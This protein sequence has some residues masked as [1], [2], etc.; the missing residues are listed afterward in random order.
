MVFPTDVFLRLDV[1][2][3]QISLLAFICSLVLAAFFCGLYAGAKKA[4]PYRHIREVV[5]LI[6]QTLPGE[7]PF[8]FI[9][10][11][12]YRTSEIGRHPG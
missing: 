5:D 1:K 6:K 7:D 12:T 8:Y 2:P 9:F 3:N 4:F 10:I 11:M